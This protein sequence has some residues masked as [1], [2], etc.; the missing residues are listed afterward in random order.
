[1]TRTPRSH[2]VTWINAVAGAVG[3]GYLAVLPQ[4]YFV[5]RDFAVYYHAAHA[6]RDGINPYALSCFFPC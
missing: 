1:V 4:F 5:D 2:V 3:I 6:L